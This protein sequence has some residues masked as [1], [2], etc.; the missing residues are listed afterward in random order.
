[1]IRFACLEISSRFA[2]GIVAGSDLYGAKLSVL[3]MQMKIYIADLCGKHLFRKM[4]GCRN[5]ELL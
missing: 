1:V 3:L 5:N 2:N 4:N